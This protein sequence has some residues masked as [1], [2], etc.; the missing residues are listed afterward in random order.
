MAARVVPFDDD[1]TERSE[2]VDGKTTDVYRK[3]NETVLVDRNEKQHHSLGDAKLNDDKTTI[4]SPNTGRVIH[5]L[6]FFLP[7]R[8]KHIGGL[9]SS[10]SLIRR[11]PMLRVSGKMRKVMVAVAVFILILI[12][13]AFPPLFLSFATGDTTR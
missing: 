3:R 6:V 1:G 5:S 10:S 2:R 11:K 7:L 13:T 9:L 12:L 8:D 4:G